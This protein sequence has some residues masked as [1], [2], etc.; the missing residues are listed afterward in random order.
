MSNAGK[1]VLNWKRDFPVE[2][3]ALGLLGEDGWAT[4]HAAHF[5]V[6]HEKLAKVRETYTG[7]TGRELSADVLYSRLR[8]PEELAWFR[9]NTPLVMKRAASLKTV[10]ESDLL[11]ARIAKRP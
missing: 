7:A 5:L 9:E 4:M 8:R 10:F 3:A 2:R 1:R 6:W 11:K